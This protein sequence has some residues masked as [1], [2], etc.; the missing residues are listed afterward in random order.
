MIRSLLH[1]ILNPFVH[2]RWRLRQRRSFARPFLSSSPIKK[3]GL[4]TVPVEYLSISPV[5]KTWLYCVL[6]P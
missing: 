1:T 2:A 3:S 5:I 4:R 6:C